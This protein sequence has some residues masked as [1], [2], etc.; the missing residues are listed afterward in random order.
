MIELILKLPS[1]S[2]LDKLLPHLQRLKI[3]YQTRTTEPLVAD[4]TK[5]E[6][7]FAKINAG[8]LSFPNL[9]E[10]MR[11]FEESRQDNVL[12]GRD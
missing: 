12:F 5:Q 2:V 11:D 7:V 8:V 9:E 4:V 10:T 3:S 6:A 1:L